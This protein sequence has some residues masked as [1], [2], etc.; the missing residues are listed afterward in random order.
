MDVETTIHWLDGSCTF[1]NNYVFVVIATL[2]PYDNAAIAQYPPT[3]YYHAQKGDRRIRLSSHL[4]SRA[5][6]TSALLSANSMFFLSFSLRKQLKYVIFSLSFLSHALTVLFCL[7]FGMDRSEART[8][9][10][11]Q[12]TQRSSTKVS[13]IRDKQ[14]K[15]NI[16]DKHTISLLAPINKGIRTTEGR[17]Q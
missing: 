17:V 3:M 2:V 11:N 4:R 5:S 1:S 8:C 13:Y 12:E 16:S 15:Y 6:Y 14:P 7:A 10:R 9:K